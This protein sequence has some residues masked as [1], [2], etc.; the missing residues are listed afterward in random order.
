M[1]RL[2]GSVSISSDSESFCFSLRF[3][4]DASRFRRPHLVYRGTSLDDLGRLACV[5]VKE[6]WIIVCREVARA[7]AEGKEQKTA[8]VITGRSYA[9]RM[10]N[11]C[12]ARVGTI[13]RRRMEAGKLQCGL[14][15]G[16]SGS[17]ANE[18]AGRRKDWMN[19]CAPVRV[20]MPF[21]ARETVSPAANGLY[22]SLCPIT[23]DVV[24]AARA[25]SAEVARRP[26]FRNFSFRSRCSSGARY[27]AEEQRRGS[28]SRSA[29][30]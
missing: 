25:F 27:G 15:R 2:C 19:N 22:F 13:R 8:R 23:G 5:S 7:D 24:V 6:R 16:R 1:R 21:Q 9:E 10:W 20:N 17:V 30:F 28:Y 18:S 29:S 11:G 26:V 12:G 14:E 4:I 3:A